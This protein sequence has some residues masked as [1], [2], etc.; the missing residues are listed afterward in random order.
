MKRII[1]IFTILLSGFCFSQ[2]TGSI[3]GVVLDGELNNIPLMQATISIKDTSL[4]STSDSNGIFYF[5]NLEEGNHTL[6]FSFIGYQSKD[7]NIQ[8]ISNQQTDVITS[9]NASKIS[10]NDIALL[11]ITTKEEAKASMVLNN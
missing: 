6:V 3:V 9:L 11:N 5:E 10:L 4:Q 8:I 2:N 1:L 7:I